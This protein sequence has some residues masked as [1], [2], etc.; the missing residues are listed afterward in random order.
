MTRTLFVVALS[1]VLG[2]AA[3]ARAEEK[4][5]KT[6][7]ELRK[8]RDLDIANSLSRIEGKLDRRDSDLATLRDRLRTLEM[9]LRDAMANP[10]PPERRDVRLY[11]PE[12]AEF[13]EMKRRLAA[14]EQRLAALEQRPAGRVAMAAPNGSIL[15]ENRR[16]VPATVI[17]N[18]TP[19]RLAPGQRQTITGVPAG[20]FTYEVLVDGEGSSGPQTRNLFAG[21]QYQLWTYNR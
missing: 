12:E 3:T 17:I 4:P 15:I 1:A 14:V 5:G 20:P 9:Q 2:L 8:Q 11:P 18:G 13:Q 6:E 19:Y 16:E 10:P 7:D 21:Y